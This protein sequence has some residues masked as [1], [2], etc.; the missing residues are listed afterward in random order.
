LGAVVQVALEP[1]SGFVGRFDQADTRCPCLGEVVVQLI[2]EPGVG[3]RQGYSRAD[4]VEQARLLQQ[5]AV[6]GEPRHLPVG[7]G[8]GR[9]PSPS[10]QCGCWSGQL[11]CQLGIVEGGGECRLHV[12]HGQGRELCDEVGAAGEVET[13]AQ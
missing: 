11:E 2:G 4:C 1:P 13:L 6:V 8:D 3:D 12:V 10:I 7:T 5:A 9:D